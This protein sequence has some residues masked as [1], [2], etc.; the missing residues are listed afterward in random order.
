[1]SAAI[2]AMDKY[3]GSEKGEVGAALV[4]VGL[5]AERAAKEAL[6]RDDMIRVAHR[7]G[8]SLRQLAEV[9]GLDRK[10]VTAV[11]GATTR[12]PD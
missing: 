6:I 8:A 5:S 9:S 10:T 12:A 4:V 7:A 3:R 11:V 1:V 2:A